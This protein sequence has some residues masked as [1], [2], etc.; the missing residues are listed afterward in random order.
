MPL[1]V[2]I[3]DQTPES[4]IADMADIDT[5]AKVEAGAPVRRPSS[6]SSN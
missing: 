6:V 4:P 2:M 1:T 5:Q 3:V